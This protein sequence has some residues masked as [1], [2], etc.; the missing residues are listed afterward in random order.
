MATPIG[1]G[2]SFPGCGLSLPQL[3]HAA[4]TK[5]LDSTCRGRVTTTMIQPEVD[6]LEQDTLTVLGL[7]R[8]MK[9]SFMPVSRIP[10]VI[11]SLIPK[12][13]EHQ[14]T[15]TNKDLITL[16]HVCRA[17][18][19]LFISLPSLWT[20]LDFK[21]V[22]K[23]RTYLK[24][25]GTLPLELVVHGSHV[26]SYS[27]DAFF[28]AVPHRRRFKSLTIGRTSDFVGNLVNHLTFPAPS[29]KELRISFA[30]DP[31][32]VLDDT[33][34]NGDLSSLRTLGLGGVVTNL[35]WRNLW[36]LTT[37]EL[38]CPTDSRVTI[39]RFLGFLEGAPRLKDI[40]LHHSIPSS[41]NA[42]SSRVVYLPYLKNLTICS[43][44]AHA[45]LLN[46]LSIPT[47]ASLTL[48]FK[49]RGDRSPLPDYLPKSSKNLRNIFRITTVNLLFEEKQKFMRLVGPSGSL[50]IYGRWEPEALMI[51]W[52]TLDHRILRS[53]DYFPLH[54]TH[55]LTIT[56][57]RVPTMIPDF[58]K[59][60]H[61]NLFRAME[62]KTL[63]LIQCHNLS[64][65]LALNPK[66][67][68]SKDV[69]CPNLEELTLYVEV[70]NEFH[71][72]ELMEMA[73]ERAS[74]GAKLRSVTVVGLGELVSGKEVF[75]LRE[76]VTHVEY[77]FEESAPEWDSIFDD[78]AN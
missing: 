16:T 76:H 34:F 73:K 19:E 56:K 63:V 45:T 51:H 39:A 66:R 78:E 50:Y 9:N 59:P 62:L 35:P 65:I 2:E 28:L 47:E 10:G 7:V 14:T 31:A 42:S 67:N 5:L 74:R 1:G 58:D 68:S 27:E 46:H 52:L 4:K 20:R 77:R 44:L 72:L 54:M 57:Y 41:S 61:Q 60:P 30:C 75:K 15:A 55:S 21:D 36:N 29:L 38:R 64:F 49:F 13:L 33:L 32:P 37:F 53:L 43:N 70:R 48:N 23:T 71:I 12:Y 40:T 24:R 26:E 17:W 8:S 69:L 18:R 22:E 6:A 25:S 11:L 3:L